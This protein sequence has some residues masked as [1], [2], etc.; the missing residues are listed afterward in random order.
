[1][2]GIEA[3]PVER[4][5]LP[6]GAFSNQVAVITGAGRGIGLE[7]ARAFARL[8]ARVVIAEV[9]DTGLQ[10]EQLIRAEGG[11]AL[12]L[13]TD[14][15][16]PEQVFALAQRTRQ[17][18]GPVDVLVNNAISSPVASVMEMEVDLWDRVMAVNLRGTFLTCKAF[19][20]EMLARRRGT[21][22]NMIS[23]DAMPGLSAY[24]ASKQGIAA[25]S[26]SLAAEVGEIGVRVI[27]LAPGFVDTPGLRGAAQGLAGRLGLTEEQFLNLPAHPA[28][29]DRPMPAADAAAAAVYLA[30]ALAE[31]YHGEQVTGYTILE[32]AGYIRP[33]LSPAESPLEEAR[34]SVASHITPAAL[35]QAQELA[36]RL[37]EILAETE[38]EFNRLPVFVRPLARNGFRAGSGL[39]LQGWKSALV[40]LSEALGS[41][42]R[43]PSQEG[44]DPAFDYPPFRQLLA[45]L[46]L[47]YRGVPEETA[48]FTKDAAILQQI[49]ETSRARAGL[50]EALTAALDRLFGH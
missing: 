15:S 35:R 44:A 49:T 14:V 42:A 31:E 24:M 43:W 38:A 18:F 13:R 20:P 30:A 47:Y 17:E 33:A 39:N 16:D 46:Q 10:A 48:R 3:L 50:I 40:Q 1:M 5:G 11:E 9:A 12:F 37:A 22:L 6:P 23:L 19:L 28:Y 8:Q 41:Q 29:T 34:P 32:R 2:H 25:F 27:A 36:G 26:Q 21:I 7:I 4:L 45:R